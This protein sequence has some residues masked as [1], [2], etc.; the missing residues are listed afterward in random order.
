MSGVAEL[1]KAMEVGTIRP[2]DFYF[3]EFIEQKKTSSEVALAAALVSYANGHGDVCVDLSHWQSKSLFSSPDQRFE[4]IHAPDLNL[5][6]EQLNQHPYVAEK[7][8]PF[9]LIR[10]GCRIY[11]GKYWYYESQLAK[12]IQQRTQNLFELDN[13]QLK[14]GLSLLFGTDY[15]GDGQAMAAVVA[16]RRGFSVISGGPGTGK[17]TTVLKMLS[18]LL[19]HQAENRIVLTAP[20]GKAAA[21]LSE[22]IVRGMHK[23][24]PKLASLIPSEASTIH[25][26]LGKDHQ[27]GLFA[28]HAKKKL[29]LD[30]LVVDEASMIDLPLMFHLLDALPENAR[31]ILLGD[32][33]Q[34]SSVE[35]GNVLGD[36]TGHG[37]PVE[38]DA[39]Q[40]Q[41]L[42]QFF[43]RQNHGPCQ[44]GV[45]SEALFS[46][47][48]SQSIPVCN[49]IA[50]LRKSYRFD[51]KSGIYQA[52]EKIKQQKAADALR[53]VLQNEKYSDVYWQDLNDEHQ[54]GPLVEQIC[55]EYGRYLIE[56]NVET[57]LKTFQ[58]YRVLCATHQ[59]TFGELNL[60]QKIQQYF[61]QKGLMID[62]GNFHGLPIMMTQNDYSNRLFNGD[63]GLI[64]VNDDGVAQ[65]CFETSEGVRKINLSRIGRYVAAFAMTIHKSQGSEFDHVLTIL[66]IQ[67]PQKDSNSIFSVELIYTALTRA[68]KRA[69]IAASK[70]VFLRACQQRQ[71]RHSGLA[72]R[73]GW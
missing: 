60:N 26:L 5:W 49:A 69:G 65:A 47:P 62:D 10:E 42:D 22:S 7:H 24:Q 1:R 57:A 3:A 53:M 73:L 36:I 32:R 52:A 11:L 29:P 20:T 12:E 25:R 4:G 43:K 35:A 44:Q 28:H 46:E 64:W 61:F 54:V 68:K 15:S 66:P 23:M 55:D 50:L 9:P 8:F 13:L 31:L 21:R 39:E 70:S 30:T 51:R 27:S 63:I 38:Y 37:R 41:W 6:L 72:E 17:T 59:G 14:K 40:C 16:L 48:M 19:T 56:E 71:Q 34:L 45:D 67:P 2:L 33:N 58:Q 18:L